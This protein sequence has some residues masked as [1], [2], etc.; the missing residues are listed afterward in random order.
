MDELEEIKE[1][2][3]SETVD[4]DVVYSKVESLANDLKLKTKQ[5]DKENLSLKSD[6][7]KLGYD[8]NTF[9]DRDAFVTHITELKNKT[10]SDSEAKS[11]LLLAEGRI[12]E[13]E[14][15]TIELEKKNSQSKIQTT[16]NEK[17]NG[18][19]KGA[20]TIIENLILTNKVKLV[21]NDVVFVNG[22]DLT[23]LDKGIEGLFK[24]H[25]D[26][27]IS[28]QNPGSN[29]KGRINTT[30]NNKAISLSDINKMTPEQLRE[31]MANIKKMGRPGF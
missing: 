24:K 19:I 18:K 8:T 20:D 26:L 15:K 3:N 10:Q 2:L 21:D 16:L 4:K 31:N 5:K 13:F 12:K 6:F 27:L 25:A 14:T 17:L 9:T 1:L 22:D 11:K 28:E 30:N 7:K 29:N 23:A